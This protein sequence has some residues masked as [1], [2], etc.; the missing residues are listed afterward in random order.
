MIAV[1][2]TI[3]GGEFYFSDTKINDLDPAKRNIGMVFQN[4]AIF[5]I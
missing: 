1:N 2:N 5:H 3:E 4:Y